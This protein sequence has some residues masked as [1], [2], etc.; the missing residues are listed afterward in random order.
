MT[1]KLNKLPVKKLA[2]TALIA[3]PLLLLGY[4]DMESRN[5]EEKAESICN[6][7]EPQSG[8]AEVRKVLEQAGIPALSAHPSLDE[9]VRKPH[10]SFARQDLMVASIPSA[11]GERWLCGVRL[12]D[13]KVVNKEV[14]PMQ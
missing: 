9:L 11:F 1:P 8:V 13:G 14:R 12:R 2:V 4:C 3:S 7:I 6:T 5:A 10:Y